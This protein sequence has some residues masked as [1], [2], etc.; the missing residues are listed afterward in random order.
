MRTKTATVSVLDSE[1]TT[2]DGRRA[3][4]SCGAR[5]GDLFDDARALRVAAAD[6]PLHQP[7]SGVEAA[8]LLDAGHHHQPVNHVGARA[9]AAVPQQ[10]MRREAPVL[11][12]QLREAREAPRQVPRL[13]GGDAEEVPL[14]GRPA[15]VPLAVRVRP[16]LPGQRRAHEAAEAQA[17]VQR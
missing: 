16:R 13:V 6:Q 12:A 14:E 15:A 8:R 5:T 2:A 17:R 1:R 4:P 7:R 9:R 3:A 10:V 11:V